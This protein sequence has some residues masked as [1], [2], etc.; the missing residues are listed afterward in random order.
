MMDDDQ[1][2][3]NEMNQCC[4]SMM[5]TRK[6]NFLFIMTVSGLKFLYLFSCFSNLVYASVTMS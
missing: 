2:S 1:L 4:P 5:F 6:G 3:I